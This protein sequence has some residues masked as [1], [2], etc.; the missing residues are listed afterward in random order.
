MSSI[1]RTRGGT[2]IN[3]V[4]LFNHFKTIL[5]IDSL[6]RQV[7]EEEFAELQEG[8]Y[9]GGIVLVTSQIG[10]QRDY[11]LQIPEFSDAVAKEI[12]GD[13]SEEE[14]V[15]RLVA[16][17]KG[18][19]IILSTIRNM[20][21][22]EGITRKDLYEEI[23]ENPDELTGPDGASIIN[24]ILSKLEKKT[25][26]G[27]KKMANA[28][29]TTFDI[30]F[31]REYCGKLTCSNLQ[32]LSILITTNVPGIVKIHDL[33]CTAM[34]DA[35][36]NADIVVF[37]EKYIDKK[38][39]EMTPSI[40]RQIYLLRAQISKYKNENNGSD[41]LTYG[42]LQIEGDDKNKLV[43]NLYQTAFEPDIGLSTVMCLIE[44]KELK[45]YQ[46]HDKEELEEY[47]NHL[48][49]E[50]LEALK[51][52][53]DINRKAE[54]LHHLGKIYR[55]R[56]KYED[57]YKIFLQ[58]L[59]IKP[60][61]YAT[62][63]QIVTLG[64]MKVSS[65]IKRAGEESIRMLINDM[66]EDA[67]RVPLRVSLATIARLRSYR[68]IADEM[69][70]SEDKVDLLCQIVA[71]SAIEDI[72]Q[73]FE[74]FVSISSLFGYHYSENCILL[75]ESVPDMIM[76][77]PAMIDNK[78]WLNACEALANIA[79][80]AK[81]KKKEELFALLIHKSI[82]FGEAY[83]KEKK[84]NGYAARAIAKSYNINEEA[85]KALEVVE[86]IPFEQRDHWIFYQQAKAENQLGQKES[87]DT[88]QRAIDLLEEDKKNWNR[89]ASYF[90][91]LSMCY[92]TQNEKEN[93]KETIDRAIEACDDAKY[94]KEL[95]E[96]RK[97]LS[98][99]ACLRRE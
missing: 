38:K 20:I 55:R 4:G 2:P 58:L 43:E 31:L 13:D 40:L 62:H 93:A 51:L 28:G 86:R 44:A 94:L 33:I 12:L 57:S 63:G 22:Y 36:E 97:K 9:N 49:D 71:G 85:K 32:Q 67:T 98:F 60:H 82:E 56:G 69:I 79:V 99:S 42:L 27:L 6:E 46:I 10:T 14:L 17:C 92:S 64:T 96:Y 61:S 90:H 83:L 54:L 34:K 81:R 7:G 3:V 95:K 66:L 30:E 88:I 5:V 84:V 24:K 48:I 18:F 16:K 8:F 50:Y 41:W 29:I 73:F 1:Q 87:V 91:L 59:E 15:D 78:Q 76:V 23:L 53:D 80:S 25:L 39:G 68:K 70:D 21:I 65:D 74:G 45:A 75:A 89:K 19:P 26:A 11:Y 77:A 37:F 52:Y 72:G 47:S 35:G